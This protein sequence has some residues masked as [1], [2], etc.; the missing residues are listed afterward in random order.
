MVP[1]KM[2]SRPLGSQEKANRTRGYLRPLFNQVKRD[3]FPW[4]TTLSQA[5]AKNAIIHTCKGFKA[6]G[7]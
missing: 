3:L 1:D 4:S 2:P 6:W 7:A 5:A